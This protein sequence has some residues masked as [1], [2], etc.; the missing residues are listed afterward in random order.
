MKLVPPVARGRQVQRATLAAEYAG[1]MRGRSNLREDRCPVFARRRACFDHQMNPF[2]S[3]S[4]PKVPKVTVETQKSNPRDQF[5]SV[6]RR[7]GDA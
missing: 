4:T 2:P 6:L 1:A 5:D 3:L 7:L